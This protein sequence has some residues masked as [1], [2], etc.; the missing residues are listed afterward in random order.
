[1][2]VEGIGIDI[3]FTFSTASVTKAKDQPVFGSS[4]AQGS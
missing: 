3:A 2:F 4:V 1:M